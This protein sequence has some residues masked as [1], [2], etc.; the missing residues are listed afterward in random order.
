MA[1]NRVIPNDAAQSFLP[2]TLD[3]DS[4]GSE[5][6]DNMFGER[7]ISGLNMLDHNNVINLIGDSENDHIV[8]VES[9]SAVQFYESLSEQQ[10]AEL[11][12]GAIERILETRSTN[13]DNPFYTEQQ[14]DVMRSL[15]AELNEVAGAEVAPIDI[16]EQ[17]AVPD[18]YQPKGDGWQSADSHTELEG[19]PDKTALIIHTR[20]AEDGYDFHV[21]MV[22]DPARAEAFSMLSAEQLTTAS[23]F[24]MNEDDSITLE[25]AEEEGVLRSNIREDNSLVIVITGQADGDE[26][27][28]E[29]LQERIIEQFRPVIADDGVQHV[30]F[31]HIM[32]GSEESAAQQPDDSELLSPL[33]TPAQDKSCETG[34]GC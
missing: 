21:T 32:H 25:V 17:F 28:H 23:E 29:T 7:M 31:S 33:T 20:E 9:H 30:K 18:E 5:E 22:I 26:L 6:L 3:M 11:K 27:S 24:K 34:K 8:H 14:A 13:L 4:L 1:I 10:V 15:L 19:Q 2:S 16:V 12:I